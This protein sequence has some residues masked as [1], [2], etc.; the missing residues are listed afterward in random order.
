MDEG[1]YI[2]YLI[3]RMICS[4]EFVWML[5]NYLILTIIIIEDCLLSMLWYTTGVH[6][7]VCIRAYYSA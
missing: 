4:T 7:C 6:A 5:H 3:F 1:L 2:S